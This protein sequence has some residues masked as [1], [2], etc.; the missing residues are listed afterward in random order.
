MGSWKRWATAGMVVAALAGV[1]G[2]PPAALAGAG[3]LDP[4][5]SGDGRVSLPGAGPFVPRALAIQPDG[6]IVA[7]GSSCQPAA[8]SGDATCLTDGDASFRLARLT[9]DGGVDPEFG[10]NGLVTTPIGS[11]RSQALDVLVEPSGAIVAGGAAR[12]AQGQDVL[13]L[14][15]YDARGALDPTFGIGGIVLQPVG[16]GFAAIADIAAGP[17]GTILVTGQA[18]QRML[19]ARFTATGALDAGFGT[20]GT[21]VAGPAY[22]YGLGLAPAPDGSVVAAGI[23]GDT[24]DPAGYRF[25]ELRLT[26]AGLPDGTFG[27]GGFA[28]QHAGTSA[29]YANAAAAT[30]DGGWVAAGAGTVPDGR[31]AFTIVRGGP[32]DAPIPAWTAQAA[33]GAG[34]VATDVAALPDGRVVAAGQVTPNA[35]GLAFGVARLTPGGALDPTFGG[36]FTTIG[37][38]RFPFARS[39]AVAVQPNGDVVTA[40]IG[41]DGGGTGMRCTG[42]TA[43]LLLA[44]Q[45]PDPPAPVATPAPTPTPTPAAD[46]TKPRATVRGVPPQVTRSTLARRGL[47]VAVRASEKVRLELWL[48]GTRRGGKRVVLAHVRLRTPR[49]T[50]AFRVHP[51]RRALRRVRPGR[52]RVQVRLTD[53]A[54]NAI[55]L[56][57][58]TTLR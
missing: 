39:T 19:V 16:T 6:R 42:G 12:D 29:S 35:G 32:G 17:G 23:A 5:F 55:T 38:E 15:R 18:G 51:G 37:W 57:K 4:A 52:L 54:G 22:G 14:A 40:G 8:A 20:G 7:A 3:D 49:R 30:P 26:A 2:G 33:S 46:V 34:A 28:E 43:I 36:G 11:G 31:Q 27:I 56:R 13:A 41:C 1:A 58:H 21:V 9:P 44:R 24:P 50:V 25:G 48:S 45:L 47:P 10:D 53:R